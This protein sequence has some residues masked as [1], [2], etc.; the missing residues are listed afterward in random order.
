M[1]TCQLSDCTGTWW[2]WAEKV[3]LGLYIA[4]ISFCAIS[5]LPLPSWLDSLDVLPLLQT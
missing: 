3:V 4:L 5:I 2:V 1:P